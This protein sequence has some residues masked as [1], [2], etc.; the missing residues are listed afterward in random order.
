[1]DWGTL[2]D[3][4]NRAADYTNINNNPGHSFR[5]NGTIEL[6]IGPNKLLMGNSSGLLARAIERWQLG[7]IYNLSSG[8]PTSITATSMLYGNGV[9]DI[10]YPV[11]FNKLKGV[12]WGTAERQ[13]SWKAVTS[14]TTTLFVKVDDPQCGTVTTLQNLSN[15]RAAAFRLRCTLDALAMAVPAGTPGAMDRVF[16]DGQTRPSVIVL[17]H[18]QP[19]KRGTLGNNTV[20]GLGKLPIRCKSGKDVPDHRIQERPGSFRRSE[21][22]EPPAAG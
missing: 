7:L 10:V 9:P 18:P 14:T 5:T 17:Q 2:T 11:D 13:P 16:A 8:A 15:V 3:P 21:R 6:P 12:R 20:I 1:M 19:G 22:P 4:T